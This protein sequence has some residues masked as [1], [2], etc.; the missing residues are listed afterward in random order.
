MSISMQTIHAQASVHQD[1]NQTC[2]HF[3]KEKTEGYPP[4]RATDNTFLLAISYLS[5]NKCYDKKNKSQINYHIKNYPPTQ[6][7][8]SANTKKVFIKKYFL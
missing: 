4:T 1:S 7:S 2:Y 8:L 6:T 3:S 5:H